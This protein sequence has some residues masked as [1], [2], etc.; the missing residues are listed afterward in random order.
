MRL[1]YILEPLLSRNLRDDWLIPVARDPA[2]AGA[3]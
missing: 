2:T 3:W 1:E